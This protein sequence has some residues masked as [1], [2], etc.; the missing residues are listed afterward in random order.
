M[1]L[2]KQSALLEP[3]VPHLVSCCDAPDQWD[4][5]GDKDQI[6][7]LL[8]FLRSLMFQIAFVTTVKSYYR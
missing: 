8:S 7:L 3:V 5:T 1:W 6:V 4:P 2:S